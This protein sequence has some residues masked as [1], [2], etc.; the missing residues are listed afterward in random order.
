MN[1]QTFINA[2]VKQEYSPDYS[3]ACGLASSMAHRFISLAIPKLMDCAKGNPHTAREGGYPY[4]SLLAKVTPQLMYDEIVNQLGDKHPDESIMKTMVIMLRRHLAALEIVYFMGDYLT[5]TGGHCDEPNVSLKESIRCHNM[6]CYDPEE[7]AAHVL[8]LSV[9][10]YSEPIEA[11]IRR[12]LLNRRI[13]N[14]HNLWIKYR[15]TWSPRRRIEDCTELWEAA[16]DDITIHMEINCDYDPT[17]YHTIPVDEKMAYARYHPDDVP[18][19]LNVYRRFTEMA[20]A[21]VSSGTQAKYYSGIMREIMS[22]DITC[23]CPNRGVCTCGTF[24]RTD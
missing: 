11:A 19:A 16:V 17:L 5:L 20:G 14:S 10:R 7:M 2:V 3:S 6:S 21:L 22:R 4:G 15:G 1:T 13:Y 9:K 24:P 18:A 23:K 8:D 12:T